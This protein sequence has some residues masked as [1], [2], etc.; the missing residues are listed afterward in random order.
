MAEHCCE[1]MAYHAEYGCPDTTKRHGGDPL[2]CPD[3]LAIRDEDGSYGLLI[4]DGG[5]SVISIAF[6]PW[7]GRALPSGVDLA[8]E[9]DI[10]NFG[11]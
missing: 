4:H 7:C 9:L 1:D 10:S 3:R 2:D 6:C 11:P 5:S 8:Q